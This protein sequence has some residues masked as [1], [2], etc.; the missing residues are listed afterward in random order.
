MTRRKKR[1]RYFPSFFPLSL[2]LTLLSF[3]P[4]P[5]THDSNEFRDD[6]MTSRTFKAMGVDRRCPKCKGLCRTINRTSEDVPGQL[7]S[8]VD[9]ELRHVCSRGCGWSGKGNDADLFF[10][11]LVGKV[12][13]YAYNEA[14]CTYLIRLIGAKKRVGTEYGGCPICNMS[15]MRKLPKEMLEAN[16]RDIMVKTFEDLLS[17]YQ[18][19]KN[20]K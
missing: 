15:I 9:K 16:K 1:K 3:S 18:K 6:W 5:H 4:Q 17:E 7:S 11:K 13:V 8:E 14:H 10:K 12:I 20:R 19:E 2:P